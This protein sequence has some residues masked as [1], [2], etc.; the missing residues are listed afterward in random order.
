MKQRRTQSGSPVQRVIFGQVVAERVTQDEQWGG[1]EHDDTHTRR[2]WIGFV[3]DHA[4]RAKK[5]V[6][7]GQR[8]IDLDEYRQQLVEI[9]A[10]CFAAIEAHDRDTKVDP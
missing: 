9:A 7:R 2:E 8:T 1:E 5:A 3:S 10:L 6:G 4:D